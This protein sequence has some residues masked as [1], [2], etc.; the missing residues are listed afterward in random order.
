MSMR[1]IVTMLFLA[2]ASGTADAQKRNLNFELL[3]A[4]RAGD[5]ASVSRLLGEETNPNA[6]NRLGDTPLNMAARQGQL[7]L[8]RLLLAR[9]ADV[10]QPN[11]ARVTPL[12]SAAFGG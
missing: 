11:L 10:N 2:A 3:T 9:G 7:D 6:R 5:V 12:M 4:A 1:I 8:V